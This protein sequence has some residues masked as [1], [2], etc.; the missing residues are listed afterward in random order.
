[1]SE[2]WWERVR[3]ERRLLSLISCLAQFPVMAVKRPPPNC[4]ISTSPHHSLVILHFDQKNKNA[5]V[6]FRD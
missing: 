2:Y 3:S 6:K 1:M 5:F 4:D